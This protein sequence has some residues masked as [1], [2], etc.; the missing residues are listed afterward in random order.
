[1][2]LISAEG[3]KNAK[4]DFERVRKKGEIWASMKNIRSG[5]GVK[6]ISNLVLK[7]IHG[8]LKTKNSTKEQIKKY[9]TTEREIFEEF[10]N[11][12]QEKFSTQSNKNVY[13]K[14]VVMTA[15]IKC[16]RGEK[17]GVRAID[18]LRKKLII[19]NSEILECPE[20]EVKSK[21]GKWF[22][23]EKVL[24]EY[25][26][27]IYEIDLFFMSIKVKIKVDKNGCKYIIFRIDIYFTESFFGHRN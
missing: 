14:N 6:N 12:S 8:I 11:L 27:R 5:M 25:S 13:V 16:C 20:F 3:Y 1:M 23:N 2:Y 18:G 26:V 15:I 4:V 22:M 24:A 19:P 21:I 7:E 10:D 9:K 17:R